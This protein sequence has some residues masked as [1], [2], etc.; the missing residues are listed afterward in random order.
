MGFGPSGVAGALRR[1]L[2]RKVLQSLAN[3]AP[4]RLQHSQRRRASYVHER[5]ASVGAYTRGLGPV[6]TVASVADELNVYIS[7]VYPQ[8]PL[9]R[10]ARR[11]RQG[12]AD[13]LC[14]IGSAASQPIKY[15]RIFKGLT[16]ARCRSA[17]R[18]G[19]GVLGVSAAAPPAAARL[20][21][22]LD[23]VA[24]EGDPL[25]LERPE[26]GAFCPVLPPVA[27]EN[28]RNQALS[29][30]DIVIAASHWGV[31]CGSEPHPPLSA[32]PHPPEPTGPLS[33]ARLAA[34]AGALGASSGRS[35][36]NAD[37]CERGFRGLGAP[38]RGCAKVSALVNKGSGEFRHG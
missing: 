2:Q 8:R 29:G 19:N 5:R 15:P 4:Q 11:L 37:R 31:A 13:R 17:A 20:G 24:G 22:A 12:V 9:Q 33:V 7:M 18:A 25:A 14:Q 34:P 28:V 16:V 6:A 27:S 38:G 36:E 30:A 3:P 1:V 35:G 23:Q 26:T 10:A 32:G 21:R